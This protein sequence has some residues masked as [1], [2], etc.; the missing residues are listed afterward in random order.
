[1]KRLIRII[2]GIQSITKAEIGRIL[3]YLVAFVPMIYKLISPFFILA[4]LANYTV[5]I[6]PMMVILGVIMSWKNLKE[7]ICVRHVFL[8]LLIVFLLFASPIIYPK[9]QYLYDD[10]YWPFISSVLPFVFI[11]LLIDYE[12]D[13][14]LLRFVARMGVIEQLFWQMC[15]LAGLVQTEL[16]TADS[17]GE[18]MESAYQLLFPIFILYSSLSKEKNIIDIVLAI[19]GTALLFFMGTRGPIVVYV[20]FVVG[21]FLFF[22]KYKRFSFFKKGLAISVFCIFY[23]YLDLIILSILPIAKTLEFSTRVFDSILDDK[24]VNVN[25]SSSRD[26]IYGIIIKEISNDNGLGHG[27]LSDRLFTPTHGYVHNLELELLC[28]YGYI[29]GSLLLICIVYLAYR[30]YLCDK[31]EGNETVWFV[32]FCSGFMALQFSYTYVKYPL[33]FVFLGYILTEKIMNRNHLINTQ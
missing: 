25:E 5:V 1:M 11:G 22:K 32:F 33:F 24:M 12:R 29:G 14:Y 16:G 18:Q 27:W 8:Y 10:N 15:L 21:Y 2:T 4:G 6:I 31:N 9:T 7:S 26:D 17:L 3:L 23:Y 28:Q 13:K 20:F 30:R 19:I